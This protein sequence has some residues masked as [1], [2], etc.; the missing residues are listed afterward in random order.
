[1]KIANRYRPRFD[2]L[3]DRACPAL[4]LHQFGTL[5]TV[6]GAPTSGSVLINETGAT[7][8]TV[9]DGSGG[10]VQSFANVRNLTVTLGSASDAVDVNLGGNT[11]AGTLSVSLGGGTNAF[12]I[13]NGSVAW[14]SVLGGSGANNV[15]LGDGATNF[16]VT[17]DAAVRLAGNAS[18]AFELS[19]HASVNGSLTV[20][21]A[22]TVDL[23]TGSAIGRSAT[24]FGARVGTTVTDN[25]TVGRDVIFVSSFFITVGQQTLTINGSV[26]RDV[27]YSGAFLNTVGNEVDVNAD[28]G[29]NVYIAANGLADAITVAD[30]VDITGNFTV[31]LGRGTD[32][33]DVGNNTTIGGA[34][35]LS[36]GV[37]PRTVN[38]GATVGNN[39]NFVKFT[40]IGALGDESITFSSTANIKGRA[41]LSLSR[42]STNTVSFS[43]A[44]TLNTF[45][46]VIDGGFGGNN[47]LNLNGTTGTK[48]SFF[49]FA[50]VNH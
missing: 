39:T 25:A 19:N 21:N 23:D 46:F 47:T 20:S 29:R 18:D 44:Q 26:G 28:V 37:G 13:E 38:F 4:V 3:E 24:I 22:P 17:Q 42:F 40:L 9:Q 2:R 14:L 1:M 30:N 12:S 8:F 43:S 35:F 33:I 7:S 48:L 32:V 16:T 5:L 49:R 6:S 45:P 36:L 27:F 50:T 41:V 31:V 10:A 34:A 15:A 11:F